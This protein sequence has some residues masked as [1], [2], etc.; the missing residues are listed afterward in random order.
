MGLT[1][2]YERGDFVQDFTLKDH[3]LQ[4]K[5][6]FLNNEDSRCVAAR[7]DILNIF[8]KSGRDP[9]PCIFDIISISSIIHE[10]KPLIYRQVRTDQV[11]RDTGFYEVHLQNSAPNSKAKYITY[12]KLLLC[13]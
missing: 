12:I 2:Q 13:A 8:C 1:V 7:C 11:S 6:P 4:I 3:F 10:D 5:D 9:Q